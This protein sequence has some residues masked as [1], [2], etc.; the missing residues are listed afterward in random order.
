MSAP[1][2][3]RESLRL[4]ARC[5][6][7]GT[8]LVRSRDAAAGVL[9]ALVSRSRAPTCAQLVSVVQ[10]RGNR[11]RVRS[12]QYGVLAHSPRGV[13]QSATVYVQRPGVS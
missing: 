11:A 5:S 6:S 7:D 4:A 10:L 8:L 13:E 2:K 12:E 3:G 1:S 9:V